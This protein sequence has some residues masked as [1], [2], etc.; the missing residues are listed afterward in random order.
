MTALLATPGAT[1][2]ELRRAVLA[3]ATE[4]GGG[5]GGASAVGNELPAALTAYVDK[6]AR[7]AYKVTDDDVAALQRAGNSDDALFEMT[8]AAAVGAA[9]GRLER[10]LA[11]VR[12]EIPD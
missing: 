5:A 7:H 8:V 10:G 4:L 2:R 12:G 6:V 1:S 3:R 11:A 9:L